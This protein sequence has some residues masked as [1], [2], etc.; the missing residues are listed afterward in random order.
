MMY[1]EGEKC[2]EG[3]AEQG[4]RDRKGDRIA[5]LYRELG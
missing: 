5:A 4:K 2:H 3:N 1:G